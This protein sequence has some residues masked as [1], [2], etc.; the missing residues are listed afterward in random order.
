[1]PLP[2]EGCSAGATRLGVPTHQLDILTTLGQDI[3][4]E[5]EEAGAAR[6]ATI[7]LRL[8]RRWQQPESIVR[9][10]LKL[11]AVRMPEWLGLFFR[12]KS[13]TLIS[14]PTCATHHQADT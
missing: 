9:N 3:W 6:M 5:T 14:V 2:I 7:I 4:V 13:F 1:M 11:A 8:F 10:R 12:C